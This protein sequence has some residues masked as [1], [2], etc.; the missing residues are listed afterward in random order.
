MISHVRKLHVALVVAILALTSH[1]AEA[2]A[3]PFKLTGGGIASAFPLAPG[4]P[5][6][7][8][9]VGTATGLGAYYAEGA[10]ELLTPPS[11]T[12]S[13]EFSS[14]E[15]CV[16]TA[17][18]G[19]QLAFT[20][21]DTSNGAAEPGQVQLYPVADGLFVAVFVAEFNPDLENCTGRFAKLT[22]GS[23]IVT[24]VSDP[25]DPFNQ[26]AEGIGYTWSGQGTLEY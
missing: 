14:A 19:D 26:P 4:I 10:F 16:F 22:G 23:V 25:F 24:A 9:A 12:L 3:K 17:A 8:N 1:R 5:E 6:T 15:P 11:D 2:Q 7:H 18:N 20:Y 13:A 21:G